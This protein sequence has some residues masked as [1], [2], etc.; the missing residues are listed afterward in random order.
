MTGR[1]RRPVPPRQPWRVLAGAVAGAAVAS[2]TG[3]GVPAVAEPVAASLPTPPTMLVGQPVGPPR[4]LVR[5]PEPPPVAPVA[6]PTEPPPSAVPPPAEPPRA[7][8]AS[9]TPPP[10]TSAPARAAPTPSR[11]PAPPKPA[12]KPPAPAPAAGSCSGALDGTVPH[13]ARAGHHLINRHGIPEGDV[14]GRASRSGT[15]DH[16]SGHALD[17]MVG[18]ATGDAL[19]DYVL[20]HQDDLGVSY[21]IWR[22]RINHGD[23]WVAMDDRGGATANHYDHVHLSFS[24]RDP[25][26]TPGC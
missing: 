14:I 10:A 3:L 23:G 6:P 13:V 7:A 16:P 25:G 1:H 8:S 15:S 26:R 4:G 9:R 17:F 22:Q 24:R 20:A 5:E 21:V 19:A 18:R 2:G 11:A 12:P